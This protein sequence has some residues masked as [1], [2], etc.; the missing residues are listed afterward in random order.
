MKYETEELKREKELREAAMRFALPLV[1]F[2][3]AYTDIK[4]TYEKPSD[5]KKMLAEF[6]YNNRHYVIY[7]KK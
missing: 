7:V 5:A 6:D 1:D 4:E 2:A 3:I